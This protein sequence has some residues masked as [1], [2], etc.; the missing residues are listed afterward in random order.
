MTLQPSIMV[1]RKLTLAVLILALAGASVGQTLAIVAPEKTPLDRRIVSAISTGLLEKLR[2]QDDD[3]T[4]AA[5][6]S[7]RPETPFNLTTAEA[8]RIGTV[9]GTDFYILVRSGTQRRAALGRADYYEAHAAFY[10]VSSRSGG[11]VSWRLLT[12]ENSNPDQAQDELIRATPSFIVDF[13]RSARLAPEQG[14]NER[15]LTSIEDVP[16]AGSQAAKDFRAPIPYRRLKPGYTRTAYLY[17]IT[18]TVEAT[19]DLSDKGEIMRAS[20]SRWAGYGLDESVLAV[21]KSMNWRPAE[22][23]GKTL[24]MRFSL[25]Y[26]FK[27]LDKDASIDE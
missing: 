6:D 22:R 13:A 19:V 18:A 27:K 7:A 15:A 24:P 14:K 21:V 23:N 25:R 5:F 12:K 3:M 2:M 10:F 26:N 20:I 9:I 1:D 11:L 4:A 8:Q 17:D 16:D